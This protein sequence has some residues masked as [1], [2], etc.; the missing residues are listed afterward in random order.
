MDTSQVHNLLEPQLELSESSI[1]LIP[2]PDK[3]NVK[4]YKLYNKENYKS[5]AWNGYKNSK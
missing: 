1:I 3:N 4:L 2:K 5:N